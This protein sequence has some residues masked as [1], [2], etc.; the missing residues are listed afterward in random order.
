M[1]RLIG[2]PTA[3]PLPCCA[4][5][6]RGLPR[7]RPAGKLKP[8]R[9]PTPAAGAGSKAAQAIYAGLLKDAADPATKAFVA[10]KV[11]GAARPTGGAAEGTADSDPER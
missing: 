3:P 4:V 2:A 11:P 6:D 10:A 1:R 8:P 5:P 7:G 9:R